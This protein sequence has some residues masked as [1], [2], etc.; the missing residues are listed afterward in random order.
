MRVTLDTNVLVSAFISKQGNP[1]RILEIVT[2]FDEIS[3]VLSKEILT[4]F[5]D[6]LNRT[7][8]SERFHYS[9]KDIED[10]ATAIR[11]VATIIDIQ[12]KFRIMKED[13]KDDIILQT[14]VDGKVDFLISG[15]RHLKQIKEFRNV[16][17][18]NPKQF[19]S[20]I[21]TSLGELISQ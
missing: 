21:A 20:I 4:E 11:D 14:A 3:L 12:S 17:I 18:V 9:Q 6:V 16:R 1:A 8:V 19:L 5:K 15:D 13:P 2:T 10:Y 7:E